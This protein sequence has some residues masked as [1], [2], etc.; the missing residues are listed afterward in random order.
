VVAFLA[1]AGRAT[2]GAKKLIKM[3]TLHIPARLIMSRYQ[4]ITALM[5]FLTARDLAF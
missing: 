4:L 1:G 3:A 5:P 2:A